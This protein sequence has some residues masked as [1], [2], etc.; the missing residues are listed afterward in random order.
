VASVVVDERT[1]TTYSGLEY[2]GA[3]GSHTKEVQGILD[4]IPLAHRTL[5]SVYFK[6]RSTR[7]ITLQLTRHHFEAIR[8][9]TFGDDGPAIPMPSKFA[10]WGVLMETLET[11]A[12]AV[13]DFSPTAIID[14]GAGCGRISFGLHVLGTVPAGTATIAAEYTAAGRGCIRTILEGLPLYSRPA[15]TT[16]P[17]NYYGNLS[18]VRNAVKGHERIFVISCH[19]IEQIPFLPPTFFRELL[20]LAPKIRGFH[21]EPIGW[22]IRADKD[23]ENTANRENWRQPARLQVAPI[24]PGSHGVDMWLISFLPPNMTRKPSATTIK[25]SDPGRYNN[26]LWQL[27]RQLEDDDMLRIRMVRPNFRN[28]DRLGT[29]ASFI[30][31]DSNGISVIP[32]KAALT[33]LARDGYHCTMDI[34]VVIEKNLVKHSVEW[35]RGNEVFAAASFVNARQEVLNDGSRVKSQLLEAMNTSDQVL[36]APAY[37]KSIQNL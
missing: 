18:H 1:A 15:I 29:T 28:F 4:S 33:E 20:S 30:R 10:G 11:V 26:N 36:C 37:T 25:R 5:S 32:R 21:I 16:V 14:M 35:W 27:L 3:W 6:M 23:F 31:W 19:S 34:G 7:A 22:Q 2:E 12:A 17:F 24:P 13:Q 9:Q 8:F